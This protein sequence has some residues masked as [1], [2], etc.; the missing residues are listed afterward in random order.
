M[1]ASKRDTTF[2]RPAIAWE[3]TYLE[4]CESLG[5]SKDMIR[6]QG[7]EAET[8]ATIATVKKL[9]DAGVKLVVGGDSVNRARLCGGEVSHSA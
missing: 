8:E 5:V 4:K 3:V 1:L 2:V 6:A 7:Y 9:R